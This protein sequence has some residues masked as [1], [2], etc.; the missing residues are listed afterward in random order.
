MAEKLLSSPPYREQPPRTTLGRPSKMFSGFEVITIK[1]SRRRTGPHKGTM[2][3]PG[4]VALALMAKYISDP[5]AQS[6][7]SAVTGF[8]V[9]YIGVCNDQELQEEAARLA[10]RKTGKR[11][12]PMR[13]LA[14]SYVWHLP[15]FNKPKP[16]GGKARD[17]WSVAHHLWKLDQEER[18]FIAT[19]VARRLGIKKAKLAW[20]LKEDGAHDLHLTSLNESRDEGVLQPMRSPGMRKKLV[21]I[22]DAIHYALNLKRARENRPRLTTMT[23]ARARIAEEM[24]YQLL[25]DLI[26]R[27]S[28][29]EELS[30]WKDILP[31][32]GAWLSAAGHFL[33]GSG[34]LKGRPYISV[35]LGGKAKAK[36]Y[37][38]SDLQC[39]VDKRL[40]QR[41]VPKGDQPDFDQNL[42]DDMPEALPI[43]WV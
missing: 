27:R 19:Q 24:G 10:T 43:G 20:N 39:A 35:T 18:R 5:K 31:R 6:H 41:L 26:A 2:S 34:E 33:N 11:G 17:A 23:E 30:E 3:P 14:Y 38:L 7:G 16:G 9:G 37:V 25:P 21:A 40:D 12:R 8:E 42:S 13:N 32:L 29:E 22:S 36:R 4:L 28:E 1:P 15:H